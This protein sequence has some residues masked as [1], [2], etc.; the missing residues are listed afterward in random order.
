GQRLAWYHVVGALLGFV[1]AALLV[2]GG[3]FHFKWEYWL[4]YLAALC[5]ALIWSTYSVSNRRFSQVPSEIVARY[6]A[7]VALL[8]WVCHLVLEKTVLP[9]NL[10]QWLAVLGLGLGPVGLAFYLWDHGTKRGNLPVLGALSYAA[11][12]ISTVLLIAFGRAQAD[13]VVGVA[14]LL[15]VT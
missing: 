15:I 13:W 2:T 4:G 12:L 10:S 8:G 9:G 11:P 7:V 5:C 14:C 6:C 3:K 1:G